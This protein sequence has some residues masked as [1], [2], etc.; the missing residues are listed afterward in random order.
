MEFE[1]RRNSLK[2]ERQVLF[3]SGTIAN[4]CRQFRAGSMTGKETGQEGSE[5]I[6]RQSVKFTIHL[7]CVSNNQSTLKRDLLRSP[8]IAAESVPVTLIRRARAA[9]AAYH[10]AICTADADVLVFAHQDIYFPRGWFDRLQSA[11]QALS[12][13]DPDWAVAGLF[14]VC[15]DD[16][17]AGHLW[18]SALGRVCGAPFGDPQVV[19]SLD[20]VVLILRRG[21]G[22]SFDPALPSFHLYGT[23]VVLS[24]RAAG[25]RSYIIDLPVIHNAKPVV[26]LDR[27]YVAAY[28][29]M[30]RKWGALLPWPTVIVPLTR[31]PIRLLFRSLRIRYKGVFRSST[32]HPQLDRP[33]VK[34]REL[35]FDFSI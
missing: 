13:I 8:D 29:F 33:D 20:E 12:S 18:D 6:S 17:L 9:S 31:N 27:Y 14:G 22:V 19:K 25:K 28:R 16:R 23:D 34:A 2:I 21:S 15:C 1:G 35:G 24:A 10:D 3:R 32:L 30:V 7:Y 5:G 26:R 11:C 4:V